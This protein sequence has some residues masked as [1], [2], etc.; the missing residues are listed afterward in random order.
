MP[1]FKEKLET[2]KKEFSAS[3]LLISEE[4][5]VEMKAKPEEQRSLKEYL[6]VRIYEAMERYQRELEALRRENDE[7]V[8]QSMAWQHKS[9]RDTRE[10]ESAKKLMRDREE[11]G[12]R[13]ID[14][15]ER[16]QKELEVDLNKV[17]G[18]YKAMFDRGLSQKEV[19]GRLRELEIEHRG[20]ETRAKT[21]EEQ[22]LRANDSKTEVERRCE[23]LRREVDILN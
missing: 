22:L 6:Q 17:N 14:V 15:A 18:Q 5:Y 11:D 10:L 8:E 3:N 1:G 9:E 7:L 23:G 4:S 12:R 20:L 21:L 2:Y 19:D 13:R 16:R